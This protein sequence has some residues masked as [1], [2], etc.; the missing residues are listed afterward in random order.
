VTRSASPGPACARADAAAGAAIVEEWAPLPASPLSLPLSPLLLPAA[1][2]AAVH[3]S[4]HGSRRGAAVASYT[5]EPLCS[6][7]FCCTA[8]QLHLAL[9]LLHWHLTTTSSLQVSAPGQAPG[10]QGTRQGWGQ[11]GR[12]RWQGFPHD[13]LSPASCLPLLGVAVLLPGSV[14]AL[15]GSASVALPQWQGTRVSTP[16]AGQ[17]PVWHWRGQGCEQVGRLRPQLRVHW[18]HGVLLEP[19][20]AWHLCGRTW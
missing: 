2:A 6:R 4:V 14:R 10:W 12:G 16:H 1:A 11:L 20:V 7:S 9:C 15:H 3:S 17:G 8:A 5:L 18:W 13:S 19:D